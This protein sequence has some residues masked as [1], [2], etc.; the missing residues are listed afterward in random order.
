MAPR[1]REHRAVG[2][3]FLDGAPP[4]SRLT[5]RFDCSPH[6]LWSALLSVDDLTRW[7][8]IDEARWTSP[9]DGRPG[10]TRW[11]R[12]GRQEAEETFFAW[13][14]GRRMAF[15]FDR[16]SLPVR[17]LAEEYRL[18]PAGNACLLHWTGRVDAAF[19]LRALINGQL[20]RGVKAGLPKLAAIIA[21]RA[22]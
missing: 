19:G 2:D 5:H 1:M 12:F 16:S 9:I 6:A 11:A 15:R 14:E 8:P 13:E 17:A 20:A 7:L 4:G 18:E 22:G 21:E 3:A 10:V